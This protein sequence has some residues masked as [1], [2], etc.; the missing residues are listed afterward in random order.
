MQWWNDHL[1]AL[2]LNQK[3]TPERPKSSS[4]QS[5]PQPNPDSPSDLG[6]AAAGQAAEARQNSQF[7]DTFPIRTN[8]CVQ[9]K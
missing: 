5:P 9:E 8:Q 7:F 3:Q 1:G 6:R 4:P 2:S